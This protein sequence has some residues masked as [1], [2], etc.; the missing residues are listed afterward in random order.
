MA[1]Q[2]H[3]WLLPG[4]THRNTETVAPIDGNKYSFLHLFILSSIHWLF[5]LKSFHLFVYFL[6][7]HDRWPLPEPCVLPADI[8]DPSTL[9]FYKL[10]RMQCAF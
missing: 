3:R 1:D 6:F 4:G 7:T 8:P 5:L 2:P 9:D 10:D